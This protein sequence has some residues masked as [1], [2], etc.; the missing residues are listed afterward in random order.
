MEGIGLIISIAVAIYLAIDAPKHGKNPLLWGILG[1]ILGL[2]ALGI[3]LI[4]TDRKV[5]GWILT[6]II[7]ILYLLIILSIGFAFWLFWSLI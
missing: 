2:L 6:I 5:I 1:F 4:R 7:A 3:Y